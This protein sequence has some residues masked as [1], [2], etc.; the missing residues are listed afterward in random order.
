M[1]LAGLYIVF[2]MLFSELA[3][4][5]Q[6]DM[7]LAEALYQAGNYEKAAELY[8]KLYQR[9]PS[10]L[11]YVER[12]RECWSELRQYDK[13]IPLL[14]KEI[15]RQ[16]TLY[17]VIPLHVHLAQCYKDKQEHS[18]ATQTLNQLAA[19]PTTINDYSL[20]IRELR[21]YK[22]YEPLLDFVQ[23]ARRKFD[24][25]SL[26]AEETAD[27]YV[28]LGNYRA[29]T[30]EY[31]K[32]LREDF[33][34][35]TKV[36]SQVMSYASKS[37]PVAL[38]ETLAVLEHARGNFPATSLARQLLS[39]L[40][41]QLYIEAENY[42]GAFN[43]ALYRDNI[44]HARGG[45][46]YSFA[47]QMLQKKQ[48][49]VARKAFQAIVAANADV[50]FVQRAKI[51]LASVLERE[52]E[53]L[54]GAAR[55]AKLEEASATYQEYERTYPLS[56]N[57]PDVYLAWANLEYDGL[58]NLPAAARIA[59]KLL[60]RFYESQPARSAEVLLAK[61]Q[62]SQGNFDGLERTL[63][64][65]ATHPNA[66][67]E[68][69]AEAAHLLAFVQFL[70][71][72]YAAS[73]HTLAQIETQCDAANDALELR[74][75]LLEALA[76]TAKNPH[77]LDALKEYGAAK[78]ALAQKKYDEA[79]SRFADW[80]NKYPSSPLV[81]NAL[82]ERATILLTIAPMAAAEGYEKLLQLYP[83]S[84]YADK[85]LF[86]LGE[87]YENDRKEPAKAI[88]CYERLLREY[89]NS[90]YLRPARERLRKLKSNS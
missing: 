36:Q 2:F 39:Q 19:L 43:E 29:A 28:F 80:L 89:P 44:T 13:L 59:K 51:G 23:R 22:F 8:E 5:Q 55:R 77:A 21:L 82:Y 41:T 90:F 16:T 10:S 46:L 73:L 56:L 70:E 12:L 78:R 30:E 87:L 65:S 79:A 35:Y 81:D 11:F 47:T 86:R 60:E 17:T 48:F 68:V 53:L 14:Q 63:Q 37:S 64:K 6:S 72:H 76:D 54:T 4:A 25:E 84:F 49:A 67:P 75:L 33:P 15:A 26:F 85:A 20:I 27:A 71:G 7:Q 34:N 9:E 52:A 32:L 50:S 40:L 45:Q 57:L 69:R 66:S 31:L 61:I 58:D 88:A 1:R 74:L 42:D 38:N 18:K 83:K 62:L 24:R 3:F